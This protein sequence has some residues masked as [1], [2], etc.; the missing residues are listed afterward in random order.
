MNLCYIEAVRRL[1]YFMEKNECGSK[2]S[3]LS[4][5]DR[6]LFVHQVVLE[7]DE[8]ILLLFD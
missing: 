8:E 7:S 3:I 6:K 1:L 2:I 4:D 5:F